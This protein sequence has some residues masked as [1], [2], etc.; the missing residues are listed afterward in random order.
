MLDQFI[1][2]IAAERG[3]SINTLHAYSSDIR[4][5]LKGQKGCEEVSDRDLFAFMER[6]KKEGYHQNSIA[7]IWTSLKLF[8]RF[9]EKEGVLK[10]NV[11]ELWESPKLK[12]ALP[13]VLT[14]DEVRVLLEGCGNVFDRA[15]LEFLYATG[16][17][18]SEL[19]NLNLFDVD[20]TTL[21]VK[22]KG[23][24]E[25][26]V[27]IALRTVQVLDQYLLKRK[28]EI[29]ENPPLFINNRGK[30]ISRQFVWTLVKLYAEKA[31]IN[32]QV[33]PHTLRHSYATHLL[34]NGA[35]LRIIQELLGHSNIS[36][37]DRYTH[38]SNKHLRSAFDKFHPRG[39]EV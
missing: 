37:T 22:G 32:K 4:L 8:L 18:V 2:Y 36:T 16:I 27:P 26:I 39:E 29:R 12:A 34:E 33:S 11:A 24:K 14:E 15:I 28:K 3:L 35:D 10:A 6:L 30:R 38:I 23:G 17:R 5:F 9:L 20:E 1:E 25:R 7:R 31:G 13:T 19:C 21:R